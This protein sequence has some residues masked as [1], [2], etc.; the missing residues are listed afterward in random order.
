MSAIPIGKALIQGVPTHQ[1]SEY[2]GRSA[3]TRT[4]FLGRGPFMRVSPH[5]LQLL[6]SLFRSSFPQPGQCLILILYSLFRCPSRTC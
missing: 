5:R 3:T 4:K 2:G 1:G 6:I